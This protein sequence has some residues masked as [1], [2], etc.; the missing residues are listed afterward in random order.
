MHPA[1]RFHLGLAVLLLAVGLTQAASNPLIGTWASAERNCSTYVFE[2]GKQTII[3]TDVLS[4]KPSRSS[5]N[6]TYNTADPHKV[7]VIGN[8]GMALGFHILD[9]NTI[10]MSTYPGCTYKRAK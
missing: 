10:Q 1:Q 4:G 9:A 5:V 7:Y 8:T 2:P 6:V 3:A